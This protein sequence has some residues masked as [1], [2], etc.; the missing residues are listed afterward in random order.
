MTNYNTFIKGIL[1]SYSQI[2]FS[3]SW[4]LGLLVMLVTFATPFYG[5]S[6]LYAVILINL[7]WVTIGGSKQEMEDG[8]IG[9]NAILLGIAL[10]FDYKFNASFVLTF[11]ISVV[12][13]L[14]IT[15]LF[16][17]TLGRNGLPYLVL[18]FVVAYWIVTLAAGGLSSLAAQDQ[19]MSFEFVHFMDGAPIPEFLKAYLRTLSTTFFQDSVLLGGVLAVGLLLIS[20]IT[21]SVTLL[22]FGSIYIWSMLLGVDLAILIE[23]LLGTNFIFFAIAVGCFFVV[24]SWRSYLC[25]IL[26]TPVLLFI[27]FAL[28]SIIFFVFG[29]KTFTLAFSVVTILFLNLIR[30]SMKHRGLLEIVLQYYSPEKALYKTIANRGRADSLSLA[31]I[32]L[33]FMGIWK[34][35]QGHNGQYTHIGHWGA[36]LDFSI[37]DDNDL[38]YRNKG[39]Y[40]VDYYCYNRPVLAP[41]SGYIYDI[42]NRVDDNIIGQ[43]NIQ[44]NWG[45]TIVI[46]HQNGLFSSLSHLQ[47]DGIKVKIGDYVERGVIIATCGNSGRSP[48]PHLHF[49]MQKSPMIGSATH[50]HPFAYYIL[51]KDNSE[52][53]KSFEIPQEGDLISAVESSEELCRAFNFMPDVVITIKNEADERDSERWIVYTDS[54]NRTFIEREDKRAVLWFS[55]D[56]TMFSSYD[57]EGDRNSLLFNFYLATHKILLSN[58]KNIE[59]DELLPTPYFCNSAIQIVQ[60]FVV[61]FWNFTK[62]AYSSRVEES[63]EQDSIVILSEVKYEVF[64]NRVKMQNYT[65]EIKNGSI[66]SLSIN[67]KNAKYLIE[68]R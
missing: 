66:E 6:A 38:T 49:Q 63:A 59:V 40:V 44:N 39:D 8:T 67:D 16:K 30:N 7:I 28:N 21:F 31:P 34:V 36:A 42:V 54:Y 20:R 24:P 60:D 25:V 68:V 27:L 18:P 52:I 51:H 37:V 46:D 22:G 14:L 53:F 5:V 4:M 33:P 1:H 43:V 57:F 29:L 19:L 45:N 26:L 64:K 12:I 58:N 62:A 55:F 17:A 23:Y 9:F 41:M 35:T 65:L 50:S 2:F 48:Y 11:H 56:G 32:H 13:L 10:A 47:M 3:R 61:P 15:T